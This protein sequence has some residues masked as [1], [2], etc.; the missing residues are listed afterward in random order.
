MANV[1]TENRLGTLLAE[2]AVTSHHAILTKPLPET[3]Q[4]SLARTIKRSKMPI[5]IRSCFDYKTKSSLGT[6]FQAVGDN[7]TISD[8]MQAAIEDLPTDEERIIGAREVIAATWEFLVTRLGEF[9]II[10]KVA[11]TSPRESAPD[12]GLRVYREEYSIDENKT[13]FAY[14]ELIEPCAPLVVSRISL[15]AWLASLAGDCMRPASESTGPRPLFKV[16]SHYE[17]SI[18]TYPEPCRATMLHTA[19]AVKR[20]QALPGAL[21]RAAA[22]SAA[23]EYRGRLIAAQERLAAFSGKWILYK[24]SIGHE[25][26]RESFKR[27]QGNYRLAIARVTRPDTKGII[28]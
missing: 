13:G 11:I 12:T 6:L 22:L 21:C 1:E 2:L 27:S 25:Q 5:K 18:K 24:D 7:A 16:P 28:A 15:A 14:G 20:P 9:P 3:A 26:A 8:A 10:P 4:N 19:A 23:W 17:V